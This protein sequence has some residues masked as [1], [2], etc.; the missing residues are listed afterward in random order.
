MRRTVAVGVA[1]AVLAA[2]G[3]R[4]LERQR[5]GA[6]DAESLARID[7][8]LRGRFD[9][10]AATLSTLAAQVAGA[11]AFLQTAGRDKASAEGLFDALDQALVDHP[12]GTGITVYDSRP[13][14]VAWSG[15]V[16][17]ID[18]ERIDG[19]AALFVAPGAFGPSLIRVEPVAD[20]NHSASRR[21]GTVVVEQLL[22]EPSGAPGTGR[23]VFSGSLAPVTLQT[24]VSP[25]Q[26]ASCFVIPSGGGQLL[27]EACVDPANIAAARTHWQ[28]LTRAAVYSVFALTLLVC[29]TRFSDLS[30]RARSRRDTL[31]AMTAL[32]A[33]LAG[34][35]LLLQFAAMGVL[36]PAL[37]S[38]IAL[39]LNALLLTAL[40][41][42]AIDAVER[43]RVA[44]PRRHLVAP[45]VS[46]T[47]R[48]AGTF[49]AAGVVGIALLWTYERF[50]ERI[51][52]NPT[53]D[54]LRF[55][56]HP[57]S[58]ERLAMSFGLLLMHASV[59]WTGAVIIRLATLAWRTR[60]T[61]ARRAIAAAAWMAGAGG[62]LLM[63]RRW[64]A[65][66]VPSVPL[67][68]A[69][70]GT[71]V[72][73]AVLTRPHG[74]MRRASR[75]ARLFGVYA[76]LLAPALAM[77]PSLLAFAVQAKEELVAGT[78]GPQARNIR[79]ELRR[80][81]EQ[82][83]AEIDS[84][85]GL[86]LLLEGAPADETP[87]TDRA[88]NVWSAT[89]LERSRLTSAVELYD[90]DGRL[91][92]RF[93]LN[94][95]E[96]GT[97]P[98][99]P[100]P[101]QPK[102]ALQPW[103]LI[104]EA[105][106]VTRASR[107][108]CSPDGRRLGAVVVRVMLDYRTLPFA[109]SATPYLESLRFEQFTA[110]EEAP[111][112]DVEFAV[113]GWSRAPLY[114][115]GTAVWSLPDEVF[116]RLV[117]S[118][119][120]FWADVMR[121]DEAFRVHFLNDRG[122]IYALGYPIV[123]PLGHLMSLAEL[124][125]LTG[126]LYLL[127]VAVTAVF[128]SRPATGRGLLDE[129]RSSFYHKLFLA[130]VL[131]TIVPASIIAVATRNRLAR[132]FSDS[133]NE[134]AVKTATVA[135][136][137][138]EDYATLLRRERGPRGLDGLDDQILML[139]ERAIAQD[140]N[141]FDRAALQATSERDLFASHLFP[142]RTPADVY[143][144]VV[145]DRMP[146]FVSVEDVGGFPYLLAAAPVRAGD[147]EHARV[148]TIPL[149]L[150][151]RELDRERDDLDRRVLSAFVLFV[152]LGAGVGYWRAE[153][154]ADP[155]KRLT[156]AT[157]RIARGDLDAR[158]AA[159]SSDELRRLV[160]DFNHMAADLKR[161]RAEL[162]R[163]QRLEAWADMARQVAHDVKNPL[164][165]IQL[166]AEHALRV[167]LDRGRPLSPVLDD[168]VAAILTQV[169]LLRQISTEFSSFASSPTARPEVTDLAALVEEVVEP[170]RAGLSGRIP[171]EVH[172]D[173]GLPPVTIDRTLFARALT[174]VMENALH[175][176]PGRGRLTIAA[177]IIEPP[178]PSPGSPSPAASGPTPVGSGS[179]TVAS[180]FSRTVVLRV[181]DT[182]VGMDREALSR[183]FEPYFST[184]ATGTG[185]GLT[186]AKRNVELI[187]GTIA[188]ESERGTG[189]T[190]TV[191][192]PVAPLTGHHS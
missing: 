5:F 42:L 117:S 60:R 185:L 2:A 139:V 160:E 86:A 4:V 113:Y 106:N 186:I 123:T 118:R 101:C 143:R 184:K 98:P 25:T 32:I 11:P 15:T 97:A 107:S 134:S 178:S 111:G 122:G 169:K 147:S 76:A 173:P 141:L 31:V 69:L 74:P 133:V 6:T 110:S 165:P 95:P 27:V 172:T 176:M 24:R 137:L 177:R 75:F 26:T 52:A 16:S 46:S 73:A 144:R 170:Y 188:V 108:V 182:G 63:A 79:D 92:S 174:N 66:P 187:G 3:G 41:A 45:G 65:P 44:R 138:V 127:L 155:V 22:G 149:T 33:V 77:Y 171:I 91:V 47:L 189:T 56:L 179:V 1:A 156:R 158:I 166:S 96:Y 23:F 88:F 9:G 94:L 30:R 48:T 29:A 100:T 72:C 152:L 93:S 119:D 58:A 154:I 78:F 148:V 85:Q 55:S 115:A 21:L 190:V 150:Q 153:R 140:V 116:R 35:R 129:M 49:L 57:L 70:L 14:P 125:V 168:C 20:P 114:M 38:A 50:L 164:T 191:T 18:R 89:Q 39:L 40:A 19:P 53:I 142:L 7:R 51:V 121:G 180:G 54:L 112:H 84:R 181:T 163:T 151:Q 103:D 159:T 43:W 99:V 81:A 192:L 126:V 109:S 80:Q 128:K 59:I 102:A 68:V 36:P 61:A 87:M 175:A 146:T 83:L 12:R 124:V 104:E 64:A 157:R 130:F 183:I 90:D 13:L 131:V 162:E 120:P 62:A 71:A 105:A 8:E 37:L 67:L 10:S 28:A 34:A 167:N 136:R 82:A 161:Q 17:D 132:Q 135:Q 145:L